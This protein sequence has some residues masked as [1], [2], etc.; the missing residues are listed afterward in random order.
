MNNSKWKQAFYYAGQR[1][2]K[3]ATDPSVAQYRSDRTDDTW[4]YVFRKWNGKFKTGGLVEGTGLA[5][6]DGTPSRPEYVLNAGQTQAFLR[7]SDMI[8]NLG[9]TSTQQTVGDTYI[10]VDINVNQIAN[11]Y[12]VEAAAEKVKQIIYQDSMYRNVNRVNLLR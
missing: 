7:L 12:D 2:N 1:D 6:L 10:N 8:S 3:L 4:E 9:S 5:W 11:D